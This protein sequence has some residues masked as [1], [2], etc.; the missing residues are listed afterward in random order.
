MREVHPAEAG[1]EAFSAEGQDRDARTHRRALPSRSGGHVV[2]TDVAGVDAGVLLMNDAGSAGPANFATF[3]DQ[4]RAPSKT[5]LT[6]FLGLASLGLAKTPEISLPGDIDASA[7]LE[8]AEANPGIV[9]GLKVRAMESAIGLPQNVVKTAKEIAKE[10][11]LPV[12]VHL[13]EFRQRRENDPMDAFGRES[14]G[15]LGE[16]DIVSHFMTARPGGMT[17]PDGT[18][19]D[20]LFEAKKRGVYLDSCPRQEQLQLPGRAD[21]HR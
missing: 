19:F 7:V 15:Y 10:A 14:I 2:S 9:V 6:C 20:E 8:T 3:R 5:G 18:V 1:E 17:L 12:M 13:G 4:V 21:A 11:K 16:G